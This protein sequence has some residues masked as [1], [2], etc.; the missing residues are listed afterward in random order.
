MADRDERRPHLADAA[1][2]EFERERAVRTY[3]H[4]DEPFDRVAFAMELL[5]RLRPA[6]MRVA[7]YERYEELR[8]EVGRDF[9]RG[10]G[11]RWAMLGVPPDASRRHIA[12]A[13]A[14][15]A[16]VARVPFLVETLATID[17]H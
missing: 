1:Y 17:I 8:I 2:V 12:L 7:V 16:G 13:V 9:G 10:E 5:A 4:D 14:E 15:L 6:R 11:A 3:E